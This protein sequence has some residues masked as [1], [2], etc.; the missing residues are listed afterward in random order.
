MVADINIHHIDGNNPHAHVL[1][2][3]RNLQTNPEGNIEFG[4]KNTNWNSKD[5]LLSQRQNW[6]EITNKYL[7]AAGSEAKIDC[8]SLKDQGSPYIPQIHLGVHA[9]AM[10]RKGIAT[11][12][13]EEYDRIEAENNDIRA[14]LEEIYQQEYT[15]LGLNVKQLDD[16]NKTIEDEERELG[17]LV[18]EM[19]PLEFKKY[20]NFAGYRL[21]RIDENRTEVYLTG[22]LNLSE[23]ER[24]DGWKTDIGNKSKILE[25]KRENDKWIKNIPTIKNQD[26]AGFPRI[27]L[28]H[29]QGIYKKTHPYCC[30][31]YVNEL[32]NNFEKCVRY[33]TEL[34]TQKF[35]LEVKTKLNPEPPEPSEFTL[36]QI[37]L[38]EEEIKE[39]RRLKDILNDSHKKYSNARYATY[40][41]AE[42]YTCILRLGDNHKYQ[43]DRLKKDLTIK[44]IYKDAVYDTDPDVYYRYTILLPRAG[45]AISNTTT[46]IHIRRSYKCLDDNYFKRYPNER[47]ATS[48]DKYL[49]FQRD[50]D[51]L[52]T[53]TL[54][55]ENILKEIEYEIIKIKA[56][57]EIELNRQKAEAAEKAAAIKIESLA[58]IR[59]AQVTRLRPP[60][61]ID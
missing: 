7:A 19:I 57:N 6:E 38:F 24:Y 29:S 23:F 34:Q 16:N 55:M 28:N 52:S 53:R 48:E 54:W 37:K 51:K 13:S 1:L 3:M 58:P 4:L 36:N 20:L 43:N 59:Q 41:K 35:Q 46:K 33:P 42:D 61:L 15:D 50:M 26:G 8:R 11:D 31:E 32:V 60:D 17:E 27:W 14:R 30:P 49:I 9:T 12:R 10:K 2:T 56:Y 39:A 40:L 5:L 25:L 45:D 18:N 21:H 47:L 44:G 22:K